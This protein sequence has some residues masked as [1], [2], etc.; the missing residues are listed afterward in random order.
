MNT[1]K[2]IRVKQKLAAGERI[3]AYAMVH[4]RTKRQAYS[5]TITVDV[6]P[7]V[8]DELISSNSTEENSK[9]PTLE[10]KTNRFSA[11][12]DA[13]SETITIAA[14]NRMVIG[15]NI[16]D[17]GIGTFALNEIV[18]W[19]IVKYP[20]YMI[21]IID[22]S[23]H[24]TPDKDDRKRAVHFLSNFG[25][26]F[27]ESTKSGAFEGVMEAAL[28]MNLREYI[29]RSKVDEIDIGK[30]IKELLKERYRI[31][32][33]LKT[34]GRL[35]QENTVVINKSEKQKFVSVLINILLALGAVFA[36][37]YLK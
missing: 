21:D 4:I 8:K 26:D 5:E 19:M 34:Q 23:Q 32:E 37:F 7:I 22:I 12:A 27:K 36:L 10:E 18:R 2:L 30:F 13:N 3:F 16:R 31:E 17:K 35:I 29:N 33:I 20:N 1:L 15:R 25:F 28:S 24:V 6:T 11:T 14:G 9:S